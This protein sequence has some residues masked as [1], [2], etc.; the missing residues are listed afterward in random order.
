MDTVPVTPQK[1]C[2]VCDKKEP[3]VEFY[4]CSGWTCKKCFNLAKQKNYV[5]KSN[6]NMAIG[7]ILDANKDD[8]LKRHREYGHA[9]TDIAKS[10][11]TTYQVVY[12][13]IKRWDADE[14]K[15]D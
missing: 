13:A 14:A 11:G 2:K 10:Y 3:E 9:I 15:T 6:R 12:K 1:Q 7:A 4:K 5:R 8:V